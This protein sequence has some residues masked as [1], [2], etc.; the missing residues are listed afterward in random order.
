MF[1]KFLKYTNFYSL[2]TDERGTVEFALRVRNLEIIT[3]LKYNFKRPEK[4]K[5]K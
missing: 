5:N 1:L 3:V 4:R 2:F